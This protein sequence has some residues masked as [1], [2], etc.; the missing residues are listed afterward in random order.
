MTGRE[1]TESVVVDDEL[2]GWDEVRLLGR[3]NHDRA[4]WLA[5]E[6][7]REG[8]EE[9][10][11]GKGKERPFGLGWLWFWFWFWFWVWVWIWI[12]F[13]QVLVRVVLRSSCTVLGCTVAYRTVSPL[14]AWKAGRWSGMEPTNAPLE[15]S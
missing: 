12:W 9:R 2:S 13:A 7:E 15:L 1:G 6:L 14:T 8:N 3:G 5:T 4:G 11:E 10:K